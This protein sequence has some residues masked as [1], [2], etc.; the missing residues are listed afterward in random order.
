MFSIPVY[1]HLLFL[2]SWVPWIC[3]QEHHVSCRKR[4]QIQN[5]QKGDSPEIFS[6]HPSFV[7]YLYSHFTT[8]PGKQLAG[9]LMFVNELSVNT[10]SPRLLQRDC[11]RGER[12]V[13]IAVQ[14]V[15]G[16][17][18][19]GR[20][21]GAGPRPLCAGRRRLPPGARSSSGRSRECLE[22]GLL[23]SRQ[24]WWASLSKGQKANTQGEDFLPCWH[25]SGSE[26]DPCLKREQIITSLSREM[27]SS[28]FLFF[29]LFLFSLWLFFSLDSS[30]LHWS[31]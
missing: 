21:G 12:A 8:F 3:L 24:S 19:L 9:G 4:K 17:G 26:A 28:Q 5:A 13:P 31:V 6:P 10:C 22:A 20:G 2:P 18:R 25:K 30:N 16:T 27:G 29:L 11:F 15:G 23:A 7:S 1:K 14:A